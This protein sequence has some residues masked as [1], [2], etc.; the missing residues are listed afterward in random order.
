VSDFKARIEEHLGSSDHLSRRHIHPRLL[1]MFELGGMSVA[2]TRAEGPYLYDKDGHRWLDFLAGGGVYFLGRSHPRIHQALIDVLSLN[3]P[4]LAGHHASALGGLLAERLLEKAGGAFRRVV[5]ANAGSESTEVAL[6]VARQLTGRRRYLFVEGAF[7][8][9]SYG[10]ISV[11]GFSQMRTNIEP[12]LPVCAPIPPD[13]LDR[14]R[15]ELSLGDVAALIF[16]PVQGMT[17]RVLDPDWLRDAERLC[18]EAG[19]LLI[20][21]EVQT[22]L[23][24]T[25]AW[26]ATSA[27]GMQPDLMTV[28]KTLSGGQMPVGAVLLTGDVAD[29]LALDDS[30]PLAYASTFAENNL[31]MAAG[32]ATIELLEELDAPSLAVTRA[33]QL[34]TGLDDLAAR[35]DVVERVQGSGLMQAMYFR[36][37]GNAV[38]STQQ[39]AM[40][41]FDPGAFAASIH[42]DLFSRQR[43]VAQLPGPGLDAIKVLPPLVSSEA[44]IAWFLNGLDDTLAELYGRRGPLVALGAGVV[45]NTLGKVVAPWFGKA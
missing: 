13:D 16:E 17:C 41:A 37:S 30:P 24:R 40:K 10:A 39:R 45:K 14:L 31:A 29:R 19:T 18:R 36:D 32:L 2:F 5:F 4:N 1:K 3:L 42:V 21:D 34:R 15:H 9:R 8:G 6:R 25:G 38:L 20:A 35:Y 43:V 22:G 7:H 23:C 12:A 33:S 44:D 28:S 11:C 27:M 26:F